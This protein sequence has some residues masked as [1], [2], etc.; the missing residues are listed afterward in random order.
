MRDKHFASPPQTVHLCIKDNP[1]IPHQG[2]RTNFPVIAWV[3]GAVREP[4]LPPVGSDGVS[5]SHDGGDA[6]APGGGQNRYPAFTFPVTPS[7]LP[8]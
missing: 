3:Q 5:P 4:P 7:R 8:A 1:D 6:I 2:N